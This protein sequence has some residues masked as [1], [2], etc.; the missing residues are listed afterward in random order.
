MQ[1]L[2]ASVAQETMRGMGDEVTITKTVTYVGGT[3]V[4]GEL[5]ILEKCEYLVWL[6]LA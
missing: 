6:E 2:A 1:I 5:S 3:R 4:Q